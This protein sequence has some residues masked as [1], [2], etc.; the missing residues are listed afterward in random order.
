M[1]LLWQR[2]D[3]VSDSA[4]QWIRVRGEEEDYWAEGTGSPTYFHRY[5]GTRTESQPLLYLELDDEDR[6]RIVNVW[7]QDEPL[8]SIG[9]MG[10]LAEDFFDTIL[11]PLAETQGL[12]SVKKPGPWGPP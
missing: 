4:A 1:E 6:I 2:L 12:A 3:D 9:E 11:R 8:P 5:V 10:L 7:D